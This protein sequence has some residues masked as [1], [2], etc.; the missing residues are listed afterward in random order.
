MQLVNDACGYDDVQ[1][2]NSYTRIFISNSFLMY[3]FWMEYGFSNIL[4]QYKT[5]NFVFFTKGYTF[6]K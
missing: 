3:K 1:L 6:F 4:L 2:C 5:I